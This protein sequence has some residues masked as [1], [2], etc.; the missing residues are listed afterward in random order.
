MNIFNEHTNSS[1]N[2]VKFLSL[3]ASH[4]S[5]RKEFRGLEYKILVMPHLHQDNHFV[6]V[7]EP[8]AKCF[9]DKHSRKTC[10]I[11]TVCDHVCKY[12]M[13]KDIMSVDARSDQIIYTNLVP[14]MYMYQKSI[15][16]KSR[17]WIRIPSLFDV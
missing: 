13:Q 3:I 12:H 5:G 4:L 7:S 16:G 9:K 11:D 1:E 15:T 2:T 10:D 6:C 17:R 8:D 14:G